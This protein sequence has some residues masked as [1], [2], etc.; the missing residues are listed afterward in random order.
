MR[1]NGSVARYKYTDFSDEVAA[2]DNFYPEGRSRMAVQILVISNI[3]HG[4]TSHKTLIIVSI[5]II[6]TI[7]TV[8]Y[9]AYMN[10]IETLKCYN[11][12]FLILSVRF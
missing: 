9:K 3:L 12:K 8:N 6:A 7:N 5:N 2:S 1:Y 10:S 4:V 11:A